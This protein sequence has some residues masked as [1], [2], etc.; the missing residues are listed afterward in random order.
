MKAY[1]NNNKILIILAL[2]FAISGVVSVAN[3]ISIERANKT[4][5][6]VADY[7]EIQHHEFGKWV[8]LHHEGCAHESA[9]L[10]GGNCLLGTFQI[11]GTHGL[12]AV[13]RNGIAQ[14][15]S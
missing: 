9:C 8:V 7:T 15:L 14:K 6:I 10:L 3:R 1:I 2:V 13:H 4:Y 11:A 12:I 5:D